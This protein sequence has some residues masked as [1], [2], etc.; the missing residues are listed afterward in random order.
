MDAYKSKMMKRIGPGGLKCHCCNRS[1]YKQGSVSYSKDNSLN[2]L[3]RMHLKIE[4]SKIDTS[5]ESD[6][7][8]R[9]YIYEQADHID[10][11]DCAD[12]FNEYYA[13]FKE[14]RT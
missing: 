8:E 6:I 4:D 10:I 9:E 12:E 1:R 13:G 7:E 2:K 11:V 5:I 14:D 3:A